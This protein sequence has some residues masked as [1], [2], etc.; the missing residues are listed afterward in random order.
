MN[1]VVDA[2]MTRVTCYAIDKIID[3]YNNYQE[4]NEHFNKQEK[5][6]IEEYYNLPR[7][8][9]M[10]TDYDEYDEGWIISH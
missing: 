6:I 2:V 10:D 7:V 1:Y 3:K 4:Y 5:N 9:S 8:V